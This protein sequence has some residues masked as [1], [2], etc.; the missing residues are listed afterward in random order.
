MFAQKIS[1]C[2]KYRFK[3]LIFNLN[4]LHSFVVYFHVKVIITGEIPNKNSRDIC[5]K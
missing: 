1:N 3:C 2:E 5:K 4:S